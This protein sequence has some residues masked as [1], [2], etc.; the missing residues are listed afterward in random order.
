MRRHNNR[1]TTGFTLVEIVA[2]IGV[3]AILAAV[4]I[5]TIIK[6]L[7][8]SKVV[9]AKKEVEVIGT[10]FASF[11]KDTGRWPL[12]RSNKVY[13]L[14]LLTTTNGEMP[15]IG[16][17]AHGWKSLKR[18]DYFANHFVQNTPAGS[19]R[20]K[21]PD[22]GENRWD[23]PYAMLFKPDPWNRT[24]GCNVASLRPGAAG[25]VWVISAGEDG[26][27]ETNTKDTS[28]KG[29]DIGFMIKR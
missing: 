12:K 26:V 5:P 20:N 9:R 28:L 21:Y 10:A 7:D 18:K 14:D 3:I 15:V 4:M 29:D 11:Y 25:P 8:D 24:Y 1:S 13:D 27:L 22:K 6:H 16:K 17:T 23:G 19:P 2:V